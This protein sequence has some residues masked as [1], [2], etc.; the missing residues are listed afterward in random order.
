MIY[1]YQCLSTVEVWKAQATR[2]LTGRS[3]LPVVSSIQSAD[4]VI[5]APARQSVTT[6]KAIFT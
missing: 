5:R 3:P 4:S 1:C 6:L 2:Y